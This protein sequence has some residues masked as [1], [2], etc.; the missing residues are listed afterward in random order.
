MHGSVL[1]V[2]VVVRDCYYSLYYYYSYP[3][4]V[5]VAAGADAVVEA[6]VVVAAA[7]ERMQ[8]VDLACFLLH[9]KQQKQTLPLTKHCPL[10]LLQSRDCQST[11][12][13]FHY[14]HLSLLLLLLTRTL[15]MMK[16]G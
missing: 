8:I 15:M 13:P 6:E 14:C 10:L 5:V 9:K 4:T 7:V 3:C 16:M 2:G 11:F 12:P 1:D